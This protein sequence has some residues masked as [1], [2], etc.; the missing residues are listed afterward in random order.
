M[1]FINKESR[2][3]RFPVTACFLQSL[4]DSNN[5]IIRSFMCIFTSYET[6]L[7][8]ILKVI[9]YMVM[10]IDMIFSVKE[11]IFAVKGTGYSSESVK[12]H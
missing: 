4:A 2:H 8:F 5:S 12:A 7:N 10:S 6:L 1:F 11:I 9:P 3:L